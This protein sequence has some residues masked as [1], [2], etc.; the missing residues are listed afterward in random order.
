MNVRNATPEDERDITTLILQF[1]VELKKLKDVRTEPDIKKAREEF[2]GYIAA[3]Y[4]I[5]VAEDENGSLDAY[6]VCKI[7]DNVVWVE[8]IFVSEKERRKGIAA[9]LFHQAEKLALDLGNETLYLWIHP[10]NDKM[11]AFLS[12]LDYDVLNLIEIRKKLTNE[13]ISSKIKVGS[14]DYYY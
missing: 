8:S 4:P 1:R 11:V 14:H 13:K 12:K 5:F 6:L 10:N 2:R 9:Q 3:K 7:V